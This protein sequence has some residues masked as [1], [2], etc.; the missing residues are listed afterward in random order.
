MNEFVNDC[1]DCIVAWAIQ[2]ARYRGTS[3]LCRRT[4]QDAVRQALP[5]ELAQHAVAEGFKGATRSALDF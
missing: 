2:I 5:G 3:T 1:F 4:I